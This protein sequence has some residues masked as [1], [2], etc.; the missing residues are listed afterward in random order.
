MMQSKTLYKAYLV[1]VLSFMGVSCAATNTQKNIEQPAVR[2]NVTADAQHEL[3]NV[4]ASS[5]HLNR[6]IL[7]KNALVTSD[8]LFME[9]KA[10]LGNDLGR[11]TIF[12]L[13]KTSHHCILLNTNTNESYFLPKTTCTVYKQ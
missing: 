11:P 3:Q 7:A 10:L 1:I 5:L 12:K 2:V 8:T 13:L 6:V 9:R 4:V